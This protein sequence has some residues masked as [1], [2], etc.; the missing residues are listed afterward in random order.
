MF[1]KLGPELITD[2]F[3]LFPALTI[4]LP[5]GCTFEINSSTVWSRGFIKGMLWLKAKCLGL[6]SEKPRLIEGDKAHKALW[7]LAW[8]K[9]WINSQPRANPPE[10]WGQGLPASK[11]GSSFRVTVPLLDSGWGKRSGGPGI[12][13]LSDCQV[14]AHSNTSTSLMHSRNRNPPSPFFM[15]FLYV[16]IM[17]CI[18]SRLFL[19]HSGTLG[20]PFKRPWCSSPTLDQLI[21]TSGVGFI[22]LKHTTG[23]SASQV[24]SACSPCGEPLSWDVQIGLQSLLGQM[25]E[26]WQHGHFS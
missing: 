9:H 1:D 8:S 14:E 26:M 17:G 4:D 19:S 6:E 22:I 12:C 15:P 3:K 18:F 24:M 5:D 2:I 21:R 20:T 25:K 13:T 10:G 23:H 7:P 11:P 16:L